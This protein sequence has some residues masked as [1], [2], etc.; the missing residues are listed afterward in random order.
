MF[1]ELIEKEGEADCLILRLDM[2]ALQFLYPIKLQ[3][4]LC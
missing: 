2:H 3:E 4:V 1:T